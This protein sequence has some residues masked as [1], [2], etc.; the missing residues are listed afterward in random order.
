MASGSTSRITRVTWM[1]YSCGPFT[2][3][4]WQKGEF[5]RLVRNDSYYKTDPET[6]QQLP[7]LDEV[8]FRF[9]PE[10]A[11][12]INAFK[13]RE[14]DAINPPPAIETIEDL[15]TLEPEGAPHGGGRHVRRQ[16]SGRV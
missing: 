3:D 8:I 2:F 9:I 1:W 6:G 15:Q 10:T 14:L 11:S 5:V 16:Y 4:S 12:L 7:F 13:A